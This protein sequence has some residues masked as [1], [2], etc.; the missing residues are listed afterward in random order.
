[1]VRRVTAHR[2]IFR[3]P[4][5]T[6]LKLYQKRPFLRQQT[7]F[8]KTMFKSRERVFLLPIPSPDPRSGLNSDRS[9]G[10][11]CAKLCPVMVAKY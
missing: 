2:G 11:L 7:P 9:P 3:N 4:Q 10:V 5:P 6:S 1:V 8:K